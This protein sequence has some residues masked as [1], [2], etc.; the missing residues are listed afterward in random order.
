MYYISCKMIQGWNDNF[1][2][3]ILNPTKGFEPCFEKLLT[4]VS[5]LEFWWQ[6]WQRRILN[7]ALDSWRDYFRNVKGARPSLCIKII[8]M[9]VTRMQVLAPALLYAFCGGCGGSVTVWW[10]WWHM[11]RSFVHYGNW[12]AKKLLSPR[13]YVY[14]G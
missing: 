8:D 11:Y 7:N 2:V 1:L 13:I 6:F 14:F 5:S 4:P 10:W 3:L 9:G 12:Y